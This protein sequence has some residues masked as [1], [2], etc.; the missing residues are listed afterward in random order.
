[1]AELAAYG[2][3]AT[4]QRSYGTDL[5]RWLRF[6]WAVEVDWDQATRVAARDFCRW[7]QVA[8]K[9]CAPALALPDG[10]RPVAGGSTPGARGAKCGDR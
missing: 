5:L 7:L 8:D 3:P 4:T 6:L 2:R 10:R 1:L 9:P